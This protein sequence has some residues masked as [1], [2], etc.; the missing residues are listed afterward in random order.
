[1]DPAVQGTSQFT[2]FYNSRAQISCVWSQDGALQ[3][4][5]CQ[6]HAWP[7]RRR[8]QQTC[9]LLP[10]SQASWACNLIL[11]APDSQKLTTVDIVTLRVLC[12]EGVRWRVMAIQDFKPFENLR[13]MAPI[14][15]QVV[16]VETHRCNI[17]WEISQA[18]HYF[19]RHLE[20]EARTLSPGHTWEEAP[21]LTLKQKQEWICLETLTPDTQY[22]FQVRVKPLQGEFTTWSPWSQ[23]LAFRTKP[24]ALGK[25][26]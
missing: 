14:S 20:F 1:A 10:V 26:T 21:L 3:D 22:E 9:E 11:G 6:V 23:P 2:C 17:S 7:D 25:D 13:L 24:A 4:T 12:R 16:H 5:S 8:W 19:E 18:S 15:L